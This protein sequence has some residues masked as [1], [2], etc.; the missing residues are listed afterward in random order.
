MLPNHSKS[1]GFMFAHSPGKRIDFL[2]KFSEPCEA[3]VETNLTFSIYCLSL[4]KFKLN[5]LFQSCS[6]NLVD[7]I[8]RGVF[9]VRQRVLL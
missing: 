1:F 8:T 2:I 9:N 4:H 6:T 7:L 3:V 5:P